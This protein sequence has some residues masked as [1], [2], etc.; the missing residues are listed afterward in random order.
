MAYP[1]TS[2]PV[3]PSPHPKRPSLM[4]GLPERFVGSPLGCALLIPPIGSPCLGHHFISWRGP[5]CLGGN[6]P[7]GTV[8]LYFDWGLYLFMLLTL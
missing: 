7:L 4:L 8:Y 5:A 6:N 2:K 3:T 1:P